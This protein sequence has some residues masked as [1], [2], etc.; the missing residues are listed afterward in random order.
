MQ[1]ESKLLSYLPDIGQFK[2]L[3]FDKASGE[4][5]RTPEIILH[6]SRSL[7]SLHVLNPFEMAQTLIWHMLQ[8]PSLTPSSLHPV[9]FII[10]GDIS[11][12]L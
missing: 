11:G 2:L 6:C 9:Q 3:R 5:L 12:A 8:C 1:E 4:N 10:S 7:H